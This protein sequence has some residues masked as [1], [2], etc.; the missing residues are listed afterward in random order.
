MTKN[1]NELNQKYADKTPQDV[2]SY[3]LSNL[4]EKVVLASS[5]GA[6]D[7]VLTHMAV[8]IDP[9]VRVFVIDTGRLHQETYNVMQETKAKLRVN[10]ELFF[11]NNGNVQ[12]YVETKGINAFYDSIENRKDCCFIRKVK[13]LQRVL[14]TADAWVTGLRQDQSVTRTDLAIFEWD[15][16]HNMLKINPLSAWSE[17]D[18]W[19]YIKQHKIPYNVLHDQGFPS[20]GC[21]P[22]TRAIQP[23]EDVRAGRWWWEDPQNKEC[24]L[25]LVDGKM[26]RK[27]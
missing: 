13:P 14:K 25:H 8:S 19:A 27:E 3:V 22:C 7:Q 21:A 9:N 24:G 17:D 18:V 11:P 6:E 26:V 15:K 1:V 16:T 12:A 5:L 4:K 20:I 23:G 10:Y 2:L